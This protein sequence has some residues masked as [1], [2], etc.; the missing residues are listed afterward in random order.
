MLAT[1]AW[2]VLYKWTDASGQVHYSDKL[3]DSGRNPDETAELNQHGMIVKPVVDKKQAAIEAKKA[4]EEQ[5]AEAV[6]EAAQHRDN[7]L[8]NTY[9]KPD[10]V[11]RLRDRN[12]EQIDLNIASSMVRR[13]AAV[14]RLQDLKEQTLR[15]TKHK[16]PIPA[17]LSDNINSSQQEINTIDQLVLD[18]QQER[19][20]VIKKAEADKKRLTELLE[21]K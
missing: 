11:D 4:A 20:D 19:Q 5:A 16:K 7:A 15:F 2:A 17:D 8:L 14:E 12:L 13:K 3:P 6:R 9:T 18:K 1:P 21:Q 10:E